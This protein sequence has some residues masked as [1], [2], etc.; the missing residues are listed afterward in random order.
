[1]ADL[2]RRDF[3]VI[4]LH[5]FKRGLSAEACTEEMK[6]VWGDEAPS[7]SNIFMWFR[8]FQHGQFDL[9]DRPRSGRPSSAVTEENIDAV[10]KLLDADRRVSYTVI[11]QTLGIHA[12]TVHTILHKHL[13]IRK[14]CT[15][16]VPPHPPVPASPGSG[17]VHLRRAILCSCSSMG[18]RGSTA[19]SHHQ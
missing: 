12:P 17:W 16:W 19:K 9:E 10:R 5:C 14:V 11:Q 18:H 13:R 15:L 6:M 2:S 3:R 4:M 1:M 7:R 8:E